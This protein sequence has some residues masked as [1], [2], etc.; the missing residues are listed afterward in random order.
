MIT[1]TLLFFLTIT[2]VLYTYVGFPLV[3]MVSSSIRNRPVRRLP[4]LPSVSLIVAAYNEEKS[5][6]T[7]LANAL[8]LDY[9]RD[10]L[11]IIVASDG[12]SDETNEIV[13]GKFAD[14]VNLLELPRRG[15][16]FAL[17]DAVAESHGEI[18][19]FSDANTLFEADAVRELV[20]SFSDPEVG[21]VCGNQGY[22]SS[23]TRDNT[24]KGEKIYWDYDKW[25]KKM[26]TLTGSIVSADGAIYAIRRVLYRA[27]TSAA[28]TDDFAIST[29]V[30]E[31]GYRL[32]FEQRA[33]A[34]ER[35]TPAASQEF[36]RKVRIINRGLR[37]VISRRALLNPLRYG[38]YSLTLFSHKVLRRLVP[39]FL[40][41]LFATSVVLSGTGPLF[42]WMALL[43][44]A[45]Y[46]WAVVGYLLRASRLSEHRILYV[47]V[48]FCLANLAALIAVLKL[49][50]GHKIVLW[51]PQR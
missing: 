1:L 34:Y 42:F 20:M 24:P 32:V 25:L 2:A 37:G 48:Y 41:T 33:R 27:P 30:V 31:Q 19:I 50:A 39:F 12:S 26:E 51:Q 10:R 6:A 49:V 40:L 36:K 46:C 44:A 47:P 29:A 22:L 21:G 11:Q 45:F 43:Q 17:T 13:R 15:K 16:M 4:I 35:L 14:R 3:L 7:K 9:P 23:A 8:E 38:F 18:L 28:I 5:I